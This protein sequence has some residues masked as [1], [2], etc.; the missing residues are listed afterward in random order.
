LIEE[1]QTSDH[2]TD[3]WGGRLEAYANVE[4]DGP[5]SIWTPEWVEKR[6]KEAYEII[7]R[8]PA[9]IRPQQFGN[10][11][12]QIVRDYSELVDGDR[13][14][15]AEATGSKLTARNIMDAADQETQRILREDAD[16]RL[17]KE[18]KQP[19]SEQTSR[20]DEA[21]GWCFVHLQHR[22]MQASALQ[23]WAF[24]EAYELSV[25]KFLRKRVVAVEAAMGAAERYE[26]ERRNRQRRVVAREIAEWANDEIAN[27]INPVSVKAD[28]KGMMATAAANAMPVKLRR[29][30]VCLDK[31]FTERWLDLNR[32]HGAAELAEALN[33]AG[34]P[35]R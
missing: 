31:C 6:L 4:D 20:A 29:K 3:G 17:A 7:R 14:A 23:D 33:K 24:C 28:A 30:D 21:L 16:E 13:L 15:I 5:P 22:P 34:V 12:P 18:S 26:N 27:G 11:W 25:A 1:L 35:V 8:T 19:T 10:G 9:R 32:K 2:T